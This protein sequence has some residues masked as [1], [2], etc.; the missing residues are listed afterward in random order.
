MCRPTE[1]RVFMSDYVIFFNLEI[2]P[3]TYITDL[4]RTLDSNFFFLRIMGFNVNFFYISLLHLG[5]SE[6]DLFRTRQRK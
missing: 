2:R 4:S 3:Y 6:S 5:L 1:Q